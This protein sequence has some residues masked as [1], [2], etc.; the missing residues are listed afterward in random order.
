[1]AR[2]KIGPIVSRKST[3]SKAP[4]RRTLPPP[5]TA[6]RLRSTTAFLA[7]QSA[8]DKKG[9]ENFAVVAWR[10]EKNKRKPRRGKSK[11]QV[12]QSNFYRQ[13]TFFMRWQGKFFLAKAPFVRLVRELAH[14]MVTNKDGPFHGTPLQHG[15][16]FQQL[17]MEL[18]QMGAE[19]ILEDVFVKSMRFVEMCGYQTLSYRQFM[20]AA[21]E[22]VPGV[23]DPQET[24]MSGFGAS[25]QTQIDSKNDTGAE[26]MQKRRLEQL[27]KYWGPQYK[28][29]K[30]KMGFPGKL[31]DEKVKEGEENVKFGKEP[32]LAHK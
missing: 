5:K 20:E 11:A 25:I 28:K 16:R 23:V 10:I 17:A 14:D 9:K 29:M 18:L 27:K 32:A 1:M 31:E 4:R 13:A 21:H 22:L 30:R 24:F 12:Y 3:G 8:R 7:R 15:V 26:H 2:N 6:P 19:S